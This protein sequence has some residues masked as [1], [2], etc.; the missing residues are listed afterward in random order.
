MLINNPEIVLSLDFL[1]PS[2]ALY[3]VNGII[4]H[5]TFFYLYE[6][7]LLFLFHLFYAVEGKC[8]HAFKTNI[9]YTNIIN[10]TKQFMVKYGE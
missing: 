2:V 8:L 7:R 10:V 9:I 1:L 4:I 6:D 3:K 5:F